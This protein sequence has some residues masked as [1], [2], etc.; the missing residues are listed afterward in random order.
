MRISI[1]VPT[2]K[3][4][5][6]EFF[7]N[8]LIHSLDVQTFRDFELVITTEGKMAANT[9]SGIKKAKGEIV[10]ILFM[11]DYFY[12]KDALKH[13][14]D[15][16]EGGWLATGCTHDDGYTVENPHEPSYNEDIRYGNNTIGSPSVVAFENKDPLLFDE[17]L[18]W[19]LDCDLY[20][21]L[22]ARYGLP[23]LLPDID[24]GIG[25]GRH[26]TTHLMSDR[27]KNEEYQYLQEKYAPTH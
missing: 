5:N 22:Y 12:S 9:N 2:H 24:I 20:A 27:E 4:S 7:L 1:V 26:Q 10:K 18:S 3:M 25:I 21:R 13:I 11:D 23:T 14:S 15:S 16:F 6:G 17:K 19:L 8:R